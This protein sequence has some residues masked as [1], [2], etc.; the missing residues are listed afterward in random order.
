MGAFTFAFTDRIVKCLA[1]SRADASHIGRSEDV[2]LLR[3]AIGQ[4]FASDQSLHASSLDLS[5]KPY[6]GDIRNTQ[7]EVLS[8]TSFHKA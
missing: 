1:A 5:Q 4:F 6:N 7:G 2:W 8:E 3:V